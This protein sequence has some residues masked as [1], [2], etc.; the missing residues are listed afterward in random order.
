LKEKRRKKT[1][2]KQQTKRGTVLRNHENELRAAEE[3]M[4]RHVQAQLSA[5]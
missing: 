3:A 2:K 4:T 1:T 5:D